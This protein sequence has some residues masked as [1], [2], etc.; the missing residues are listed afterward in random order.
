MIDPREF[1]NALSAFATGVTI[2][3][4][5][6]TERDEPVG[7][8]ASSF[9]SVSIEPPLILWSVT[10][11]AQ[12]APVFQNA[13]DFS[14]H[15]LSFDQT[16]VSNRFAR[17]GEDKFGQTAHHIDARGV[18]ILDGVASRFDCKQWAVYEG[19][20]HWIIVGEVI[21]FERA[22]K[23]GLVFSEGSYATAAPM[24]PQS[25]SEDK[26]FADAP[27]ENLLFYHLSRAYH[28]MSKEFHEEVARNRLTLGEWRILVSLAGQGVEREISDLSKRT[29]IEQEALEDLIAKLNDQGLCECEKRGETL[30]VKRTV[31]GNDRI[32]HLIM[33][34]HQYEKEIFGT[35]GSKE[36]AAL[37]EGLKKIIG[38][39]ET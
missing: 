6:D 25:A 24:T 19:G 33:L 27:V 31:A 26:D 17:R 29:F 7:M 14:V 10:K 2:V 22:S 1:R 8:T 23:D 9:N 13:K 38:A 32:A 36:A 11:A 20:D 34:S 39:T 4:A 30:V 35:Q 37:I 15:V 28:E 12:S 3:T 21:G 18:P 16:E 5:Y